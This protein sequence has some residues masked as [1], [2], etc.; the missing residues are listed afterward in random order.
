MTAGTIST[1]NV[2]S[3]VP[4][5][6]NGRQVTTE[7]SFEVQNPSTGRILWKSSAASVHDATVAV[8]SA[9]SAFQA[10]S[11]TKPAYRRDLFLRAANI[12]EKRKEEL[13]RYM[14][15]ETGAEDRFVDFN[16]ISCIEMLRDLAG[17]IS[18][19]AGSMPTLSE[20][21]AHGL[22][23]MEPYGVVLG[24][25]PWN[26]PFPLGVRAFAFALAAGNTV[27]LKGSE[28]A[29]RT[30]FEIVNVFYEAS[31]PAG[32]VNLIVHAPKSAAE[33][34]TALVTHPLVKK[35][36]FTGST[37]IGK[38]IASLAGQYLKPVLMELGGKA[39]AIIM[40]DANLENA[41]LQ[42]TLGSFIHSGQVCMSTERVVVHKDVA[43]AFIQEFKKATNRIYGPSSPTPVL[44][45]SAGVSKNK[46]LISDAMNKG[47]TVILGSP[48]AKESLDTHLRPT[49]LCG[50]KNDMDL[51]YEESFGPTVSVFVVN[52]EEEALELANDT[53]YGL[54]GAVFTENLA[55]GLRIAEKYEA[56]AIHINSMTVHDEPV[57]PHGGMKQSGFGRFNGMAGLQEFLRTK[58]VTWHD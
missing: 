51:Y 22:I 38:I 58:T 41:A 8:D 6:I 16:L 30:F 27:V 26:S 20:E 23:Y 25:A 12:F 1:A 11:K 52:S 54:V 45:S 36:N 19:I 18:S 39:S 44:V 9:H 28:F 40:N 13:G 4:L 46:R 29:P 14:T 10:W 7:M 37:R 56:G 48:E 55:T 31:L 3:Q 42:C 53:E 33:V 17:R 47:A 24:I 49:I 2:D 43:E 21:G 50:V 35:I 57:L 5:I 15:E 32:C 34:T